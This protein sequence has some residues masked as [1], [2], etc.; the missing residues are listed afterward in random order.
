MALI[1]PAAM[2]AKSTRIA[3]GQLTAGLYVTDHDCFWSPS[4]C[5]SI[6]PRHKVP[7]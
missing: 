7:T 4:A 3:S 1:V 5:Q 2:P 6:K